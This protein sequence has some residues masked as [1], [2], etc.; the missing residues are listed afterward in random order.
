MSCAVI[1]QLSQ[2]KWD[3]SEIKYSINASKV[4]VNYKYACRIRG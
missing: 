3:N 4:G 1:I 2:A